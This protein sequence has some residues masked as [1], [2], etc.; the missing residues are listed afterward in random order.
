M[1]K[2]EYEALRYFFSAYYTNIW[3][4]GVNRDDPYS[5]TEIISE[6]MSGESSDQIQHTIVELELLIAQELPESELGRKVTRELGANI[7]PPGM[8]LTYQQ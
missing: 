8:G 4:D 1:V 2:S 5:Y 7:Y 3:V 6:F